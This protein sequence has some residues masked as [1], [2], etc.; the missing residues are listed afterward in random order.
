MSG[1]IAWL[2]RHCQAVCLLL[3]TLLP[4]AGAVMP[5]AELPPAPSAVT[6]VAVRYPPVPI[7]GS[8]WERTVRKREAVAQRTSAC[9]TAQDKGKRLAG[10]GK[11][12]AGQKGK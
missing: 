7:A 6:P 5:T 1:R 10:C 9:R 11:R 12:P 2:T 8:A 3:P 4:A